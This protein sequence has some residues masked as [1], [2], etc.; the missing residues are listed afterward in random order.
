MHTGVFGRRGNRVGESEIH[1]ESVI[2]LCL[3]TKSHLSRNTPVC[4]VT[5]LGLCD[6]L[7]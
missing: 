1:I 3:S 6:H 5:T 2:Y 4:Y 7:Q